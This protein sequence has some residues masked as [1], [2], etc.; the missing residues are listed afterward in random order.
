MELAEEK[1]FLNI[2]DFYLKIEDITKPGEFILGSGHN[3]Q[4]RAEEVPRD[5]FRVD[6]NLL[7]LLLLILLPP[8][9]KTLSHHREE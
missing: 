1:M 3:R 6:G 4:S 2:V 8:F 5:F 9:D 7:L